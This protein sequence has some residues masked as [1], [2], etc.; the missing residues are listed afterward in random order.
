MRMRMLRNVSAVVLTLGLGMAGI[1]VAQPAVA[2]PAAVR[3]DTDAHGTLSV[4]DVTVMGKGCG[5]V[6]VSFAPSVDLVDWSLDVDL[7]N[8]I[9]NDERIKFQLDATHLSHPITLCGVRDLP[10]GFRVVGYLQGYLESTGNQVAVRYNTY[11]DYRV[12]D[13]KPTAITVKVTRSHAKRC[14][15]G[16]TAHCSLVSGKVTRAGKPVKWDYVQIQAYKRHK[17][18]RQAWGR[19]DGLGRV[20]WYVTITKKERKLKLRLFYPTS[21]LAKWSVSKTFKAKY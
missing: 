7:D 8:S 17:W 16:K 10:G 4:N 1:V 15:L 18:V 3:G 11:F 20:S 2:L 14:P 19:C 5:T 21:D 6:V 13:R 12:I 9:R